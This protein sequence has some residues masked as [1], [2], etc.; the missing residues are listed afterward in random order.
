MSITQDD[1]KALSKP[2]FTLGDRKFR[3]RKM[4]AM[5]AVE[6]SE[7]I[8]VELGKMQV[9]PTPDMLSAFFQAMLQFP[10]DFM[11][12]LR[13]TLFATVTFSNDGRQWQPVADAE[14]MAFEGLEP[15]HVYEVMMRVLS[16]DFTESF[17]VILRL[18]L[19][20][21]ATNTPPQP[22]PTSTPSSPS[23]SQ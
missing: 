23:P 13:E 19:A 6:V 10:K 12:E 22:Q 7:A 18:W 5:K 14:D 8:R 16:V 17:G 20:G 3:I 9:Q 4:G 11:A 21:Q 1:L 15:H 2:A